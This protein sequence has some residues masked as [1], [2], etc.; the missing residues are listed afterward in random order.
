LNSKL[1]VSTTDVNSLAQRRTGSQSSLPL[2]GSRLLMEVK[3]GDLEGEK[4]SGGGGD[5][6]DGSPISPKTPTR[7]PSKHAKA[8]T[9]ARRKR[10]GPEESL[11]KL[12]WSPLMTSP[13]F[14]YSDAPESPMIDLG[15]FPMILEM[16][17]QSVSGV[18][19]F[20]CLLF[21]TDHV[22]FLS[23]FSFFFL[24]AAQV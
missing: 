2:N 7:T 15:S 22:R 20:V 24:S 1:S 19:C 13:S 12:D 18:P 23:F 10:G 14:Q 16:A 17:I 11:T 4:E 21:E 9:L 3:V 6:G 5:G 8:A